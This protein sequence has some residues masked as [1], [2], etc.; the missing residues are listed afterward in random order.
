MNSI[1]HKIISILHLIY[2]H[3]V[4]F[5]QPIIF[6]SIIFTCFFNIRVKLKN[7]YILT[8]KVALPLVACNRWASSSPVAHKLSLVL[9]QATYPFL[10]QII[11]RI[12]KIDY[13]FHVLKNKF[14]SKFFLQFKPLVVSYIF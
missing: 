2:P 5:S 6:F 4:F 14:F 13:L 1:N 3:I 11:L 12:I 8:K 7:T 10:C 9:L